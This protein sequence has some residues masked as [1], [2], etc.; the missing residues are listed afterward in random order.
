MKQQQIAASDPTDYWFG[1]CG[2]TGK[3][4]PLEAGG[5]AESVA[6][7]VAGDGAVAGAVVAGGVVAAPLA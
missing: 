3:V 7:G 2:V 6:G 4:T 1:T 5:A